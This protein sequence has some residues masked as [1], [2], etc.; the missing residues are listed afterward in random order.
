M[1][2]F[3]REVNKLA[4]EEGFVIEDSLVSATSLVTTEVV[5]DV[6][7]DKFVGFCVVYVG[8]VSS[9]LHTY[10]YDFPQSL[11]FHFPSDLIIIQLRLLSGSSSSQFVY[12]LFVPS[13][14]TNV[15]PTSR[16][17]K[18]IHASSFDVFR[19]KAFSLA[20]VMDV[21]FPPLLMQSALAASQALD[22]VTR[23]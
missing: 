15:F 12:V 23:R 17:F 20:D 4:V 22:T 7:V 11:S 2:P 10:G 9:Y 19:T 14:H 21:R 8:G 6:V 13:I 1:I 5:A 3:D 16:S 18:P